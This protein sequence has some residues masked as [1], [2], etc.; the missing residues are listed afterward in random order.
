MKRI[1]IVGGGFGGAYCAQALERAVRGQDVEILLIDRHNFFAFYPLLVEAGTGSLEP[2]H[3]VVSIRR[4]L[5]SSR[6]RMAEVL[7]I[8]PLRRVVTWRIE[9]TGQIEETPYDHLV[10]ALGSVTRLP[11]VPGLLQHGFELKGLSDAVA[12]RDRAIALLEAAEASSNE[13][14]RRALLHWVV[15]GASFTGVELAGEFH[16]FLRNACRVYPNLRPDQCR[17]TLLELG[18]RI[19]PA[20]D[21][22]LSEYATRQLRRR[23]L[24]VRLG[25]SVTRIEPDSVVLSDGEVLYANTVVWCAGIAPNPLL[26]RLPLP[27]DERGYL[28]TEPDLRVPGYDTIWGIGDCAVNPAPDGRPYAATAQNAVRQG[29]H[30]A[31]NIA[32]VLRSQSPRAMNYRPA[33]ALA[34]LGCRTGVALVFGVKLSGFPAWFVWRSA[35]LL[36]MP[37]WWRRAR[38]A[39]DWT[40]DLFFPRDVV[41]LGLT[42]RR[43][44]AARPALVDVPPEGSVPDA[45]SVPSDSVATPAAAADPNRAGPGVQ[46]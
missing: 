17:I 26:T 29:E 34:A 15:V 21:P 36:K 38:I 10:L 2:R 43:S 16:V 31:R 18:D 20:L 30:L 23:G 7:D 1:I 45:D 33:G 35:Y 9:A 41:Q 46:A 14:Q 22:G 37:G 11:P 24:D 25:T 42:G 19:L 13:R 44:A 39:I 5:R 32:R 4:Y 28:I 40:M 6:F 12:L 8:D 3:A 27:L